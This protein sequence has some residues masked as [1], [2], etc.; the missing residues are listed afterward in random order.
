LPWND[1]KKNSLLKGEGTKKP[2][3]GGGVGSRGRRFLGRR[4]KWKGVGNKTSSSSYVGEEGVK[5][6]GGK[7][8][9]R[10]GLGLEVN[11]P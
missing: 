5:L 7:T 3:S 1:T 9:Q 4:G 8:R 10:V 2:G 6:G 11:S